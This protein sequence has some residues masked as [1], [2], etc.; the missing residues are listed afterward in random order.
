VIGSVP[1]FKRPGHR[2]RTWRNH[3]DDKKPRTEVEDREPD[4]ALRGRDSRRTIIDCKSL[5]LNDIWLGGRDSS[6][7]ALRATADLIMSVSHPPESRAGLCRE[8]RRMAGRQGF[9][10]RAASAA[11]RSKPRTVPSSQRASGASEV[12]WEAGI[13]TPITWSRGL[14]NEAT[15]RAVG[16]FCE[17][18][19]H[20]ARLG[21]LREVGFPQTV[22]RYSPDSQLLEFLTNTDGVAVLVDQPWNREGADLEMFITTSSWMRTTA[23]AT[24]NGCR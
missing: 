18:C 3:G 10:P 15:L 17:H 23:A 14:A 5:F 21:A 2:N 8:R 4:S 16:I 20:N 6:T 11:S 7:F 19:A 12:G 24:A 9:V 22:T 13:R 1:A